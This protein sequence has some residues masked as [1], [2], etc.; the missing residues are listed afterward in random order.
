MWGKLIITSN[1]RI[2]M[3]CFILNEKTKLEIGPLYK[4]QGLK[5]RQSYIEGISQ[6]LKNSKKFLS[7][8]FNIFLVANDKYN[9]YPSIAQKA[10]LKIL[11][12]FK[13]PVLNRT[14]RDKNPYSE[15]IFHLK[16]NT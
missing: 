6:V 4:G 16:N 7:K 8:D 10:G 11:N 13:R 14:E 15:T 2:L 3:T 1:M 12:Q 9:L 5:A